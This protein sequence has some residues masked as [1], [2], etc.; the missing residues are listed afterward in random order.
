MVNGDQGINR[1][2]LF[3]AMAGIWPFGRGRIALPRDQ[4]ISFVPQNGY[5][6][7]GR[8]RSLLAYPVASARFS[9]AEMIEALRTVGLADLTGRLDERGR[10]ERI[11]DKDQQ[12][13]L[14][15]A[16][17]LIRKPRWLVMHD[18]LEGLEP[19]TERRL[20]SIL[21]Q[22]QDATLIYLGRSLALADATGARAVHL[23]KIEA[24]RA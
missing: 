2:M 12:M 3:H 14:A 23:E 11:L 24:E 20:T 10:W 7:E 19:D 15:F 18:V 5:L 8:L 1:K 6:P 13:A 4:D 9:D 16:N 21:A 22:M 17:I